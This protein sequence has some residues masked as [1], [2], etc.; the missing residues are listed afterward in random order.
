MCISGVAGLLLGKALIKPGTQTRV[1][2]LK[3]AATKAVPLIVGAGLMTLL[4]AFI[5]AYWSSKDLDF[6][7]K[8]T[9]GI[10]IWILH[11]V[12]LTFAGR[13]SGHHG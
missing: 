9:V 10:I 13:G 3:R 12:Y 7:V 4:A 2:A 11:I 6:S 8:I 1:L 5:E